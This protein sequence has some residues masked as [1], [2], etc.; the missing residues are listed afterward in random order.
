M[1][2]YHILLDV[3]SNP[4]HTRWI[5]PLLFTADAVLCSIVIWKI[6]CKVTSADVRDRVANFCIDTEIDWIAYMEQVSQFIAGE[7]DYTVIKGTTGPLVYPA[8][9]VYIYTG[10]YYLTDKGTNVLLGQILFAG[11]YLVTLAVVMACYRLAKV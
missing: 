5:S 4:E 8:A 7:R 2:L 11:L 10:L 1:E 3:W 9:H 6:P